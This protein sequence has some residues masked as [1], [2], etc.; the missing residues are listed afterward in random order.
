[1]ATAK[2]IAQCSS[3]ANVE[4]SNGAMFDSVD[5]SPHGKFAKFF[6]KGNTILKGSGCKN[7]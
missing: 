1:V 7:I 5:S 6:G 2:A 3:F 4:D